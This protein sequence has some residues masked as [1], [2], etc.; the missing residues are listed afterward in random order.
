[1]L[2]L[3]IL[4]DA[5]QGVDVPWVVPIFNEPLVIEFTRNTN[6]V[7]TTNSFPFVT[8]PVY[9]ITD[10]VFG[11]PVKGDIEVNAGNVK[12]IGTCTFGD[13]TFPDASWTTTLKAFVI[14]L[15]SVG[16]VQYAL[17]LALIILLDAS[18]DVAVPW[19]VPIFNDPLVNE[20]TRKT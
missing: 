1:M 11:V 2:A 5:S 17:L 15:A 16:G 20:F 8:R 18:Q 3:I 7:L 4:L 6:G 9:E 10:K 14:P 13:D 19:V 12:F